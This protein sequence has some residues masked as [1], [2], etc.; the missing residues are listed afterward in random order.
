MLTI[1]DPYRILQVVP[2]AEPEVIRAAYRALA[3]KYHPDLAAASQERM[4]TMGEMAAQLAHVAFGRKF[5][6]LQ[7]A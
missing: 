7:V 2:D 4:A 6:L 5:R 1:S 3:L